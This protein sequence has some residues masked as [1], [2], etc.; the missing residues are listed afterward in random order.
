MSAHNFDNGNTFVRGHGIAELVNDI[1]A[2]I[3]RRIKTEGI[4]G[5]R[6]VVVNRTGDT[7]GRHAVRFT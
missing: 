4:I 6:Q 5:V 3:Y 2:S 1:Q 7:D